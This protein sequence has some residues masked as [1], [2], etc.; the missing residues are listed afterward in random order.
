MMQKF[1]DYIIVRALVYTAFGLVTLWQP[2]WV[3]QM[4]VYLI[5]AYFFLMGSLRLY[6]GVKTKER[7]LQMTGWGA[8]IIV[9]V[10]LFFA[11]P[12]AALLPILLGVLVVGAGVSQWLMSMVFRQSGIPMTPWQIWAVVLIV[13]GILLMLNPFQSILIVI[14]VFGGMTL[15]LGISEFLAFF[16]YKRRY[17]T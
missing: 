2:K 13:V 11:K 8:Y 3:F 6:Q 10:L 15:L 17:R 4:I 14:Q 7:T 1:H 16:E 9:L 5:M 12:L